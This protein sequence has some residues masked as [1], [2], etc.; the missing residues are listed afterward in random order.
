MNPIRFGIIGGGWRAEFFIRVA[1]ALPER[2]HVE[3]VLVRDPAKAAA[4]SA[5]MNV[6][7]CGTMDELLTGTACEYVVLSV[8]CAANPQLLTELTDRKMPVL[9]ETPPGRDEAAMTGL[10]DLTKRGAR[11]QVAEQLHLRPLH[12]ARIAMARSGLLGNVHQA[13]VA[14]AHGY[15]GISLIRRLLGIG[16]EDVTITAKRVPSTVM[17]GPGRG[18]SPTEETTEKVLQEIAWMDFGDR[19]GMF[20]FAGP[21][22][23]S[24]V[25]SVRMLVQGDRGEIHDEEVRYLKDFRTPVHYHLQREVAGHNDNLEGFHLRGIMGGDQ[26]VY[27]NPYIPARLSDDEIAVASCLEK[28]STYAKGG[29]DFYSLAEGCQDNYLAR[30]LTQAA[31]SGERVKSQRQVWAV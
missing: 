8:P 25:R 23:F 3:R 29:P 28:M 18:G 17:G 14:I 27:V 19:L 20:D 9:V 22:Y 21:Q 1:Q 13:Q 12:A 5:R 4:F 6:P 30:L 2:F 10:H 26:W 11:I 7:T 15:H 31:K 16:F 24:W